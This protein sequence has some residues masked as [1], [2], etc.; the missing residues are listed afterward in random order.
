MIFLTP[1]NKEIDPDA[2]TSAVLDRN[3]ATSYALD[4]ETGEVECISDTS[5]TAEEQEKISDRWEVAPQRY[6][7]I[8]RIYGHEQY[9]W[10]E[11]FIREIVSSDDKELANALW[12]SLEGANV[13]SRFYHTLRNTGDE[14]LVCWMQWED[15][16]A[17]EEIQSWLATLPVD[18]TQDPPL[19][20]DCNMCKEFVQTET[21]SQQH[22]R[23]QH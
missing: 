5:D 15:D 8:P 6:F 7:A 3:L 16:S 19:S 10:R 9:R 13:F 20:A 17:L 4:I 22:Q 14:W 21:H 1:T 18:I 11:D 2:L 12:K 23:L